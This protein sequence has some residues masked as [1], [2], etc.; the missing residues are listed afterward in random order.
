MKI[1]VVCQ[2]YWPE[3]YP[4]QDLCEEF[5]R[6]GHTIHVVTGV[7]NYPMGVIY[8]EYRKG[9]NREQLLN[10][11]KV[12]RVFTIGRRRSALFRFLNYYSYAISSSLYAKKTR[13]EYDVVFVHQTSPVMMASAAMAYAK[14]WRKNVVLYCMDLWPACLAAGGVSEKSPIYKLFGRVSEKLYRQ[15]SRILITSQMFKEYLKDKFRIDDDKI[16][17]V[18]QYA[19][20]CFSEYGS[21]V[22]KDT[23]DLVFAGNIG[24]AQSILRQNMRAYRVCTTVPWRRFRRLLPRICCSEGSTILRLGS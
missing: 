19:A 22:H 11:V 7:P 17:Y 10:G 2:H 20:P 16:A 4:L 14:K 1:L 24:A 6:R 9:K 15:A 3:P 13:E 8:P 5:V 23:V 18:P 12:T 21:K